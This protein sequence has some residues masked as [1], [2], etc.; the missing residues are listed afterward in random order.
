MSA[1][2]NHYGDI[3][4]WIEKVIDSCTHPLH[5]K[6]ARKLIRQFEKY[7]TDSLDA[8]TYTIISR[9]LNQRLDDK[10]YSR[11]ENQL[12]NNANTN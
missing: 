2:S 4:L 11:I 5:E 12:N 10:F 3:I 9:E 7:Y 8:S 1:T 6:A